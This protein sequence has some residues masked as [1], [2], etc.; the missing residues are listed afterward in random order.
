MQEEVKTTPVGLK[1][2]LFI[3]FVVV[4]LG[5]G[6]FLRAVTEFFKLGGWGMWPILATALLFIILT[7]DRVRYLYFRVTSHR[8]ELV[9]EVQ[10]HLMAGDVAS[11]VS[12][13]RQ[14]GTPMAHI[15]GA[16]LSNLRQT[17]DEVQEAVDEAALY[18]LP[19]I[20]K[21]TGYLAMMGNIATLLGLLGTIIGLI[22]SFAGVS[23]ENENDP[24]SQ[25]RA[26]QYAHLVPACQGA[27]GK[28]LVACIKQNKATILAKGISEAMNCTAFGLFVG[29]L[30]L[31]AYSVLNGRTQH[32]LDDIN[33]GVTQ[34]LNLAVSH[35]K[36][37]K[38]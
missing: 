9:A 11:A 27:S 38:A 18:E 3:G 29:I 6:F 32:L 20:E 35:R 7:V 8:R 19:R 36:A 4:W 12:Y 37:L 10:K 28:A 33:D 16:G 24:A 22:T 34:I 14:A 25:A 15:V 23:L 31:L 21:R 5:V 30:A 13:C 2:G 1:V 26:Q 17:N